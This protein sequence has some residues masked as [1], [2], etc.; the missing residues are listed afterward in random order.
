MLVAAP[1]MVAGGRCEVNFISEYRD[2]LQSCRVM[3]KSEFYPILVEN[4]QGPPIF[5]QVIMIY[6]STKPIFRQIEAD[7]TENKALHI[8]S[9]CLTHPSYTANVYRSMLRCS[10]HDA[11]FSVVHPAPWSRRDWDVDHF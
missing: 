11:A 8:Q 4:V 2:T 6:V 1:C 5:N 9:E 10:A 7:S 3:G